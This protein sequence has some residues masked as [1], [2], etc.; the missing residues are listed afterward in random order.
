MVN[1]VALFDPQLFDTALFDTGAPTGG[2]GMKYMTRRRRRRPAAQLIQVAEEEF[3]VAAVKVFTQSATIPVS[4][5]K[6]FTQTQTYVACIAKQITNSGELFAAIRFYR[7][8][9]FQL[10]VGLLKTYS[11]E[12]QLSA[13]K[14]KPIQRMK[15][16]IHILQAAVRALTAEALERELADQDRG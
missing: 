1:F 2:V 5:G 15:R 16:Q 7:Q 6:G 13:M 8:E 12:I 14:V 3:T 9:V 11:E 10:S 4:V